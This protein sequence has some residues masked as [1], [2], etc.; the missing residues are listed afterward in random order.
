MPAL[1]FNV[2]ILTEN[3]LATYQSHKSDRVQRKRLSP[4]LPDFFPQITYPGQQPPGETALGNYYKRDQTS[5]NICKMFYQNTF[6]F[7]QSQ[8]P[9]AAPAIHKKCTQATERCR[10]C[11]M[12]CLFP[13]TALF[14]RVT[15]LSLPLP[16]GGGP[17]H[18]L[19]HAEH[20]VHAHSEPR[21]RD[22]RGADGEQDKWQRLLQDGREQLQDVCCL[23]RSGLALR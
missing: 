21:Q 11:W 16:Q 1:D 10:N 22:W 4:K 13:L 15:A 5:L 17:V 3:V 14:P 23:L 2:N 12:R 8:I 20:S 7:T 19:H 18:G 6:T 9:S